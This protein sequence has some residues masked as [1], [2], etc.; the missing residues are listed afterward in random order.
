MSKRRK[1][2]GLRAN[3]QNK[4]P[5]Y[6]NRLLKRAG[7]GVDAGKLPNGRGPR[8]RKVMRVSR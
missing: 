7:M 6:W 1:R 3:P 2:S 4:S 5:A 8:G